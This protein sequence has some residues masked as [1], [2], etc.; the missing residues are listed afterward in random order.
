[1]RSADSGTASDRPR[2]SAEDLKPSIEQP[3]EADQPASLALSNSASLS[4][5]WRMAGHSVRG[6]AH[7]KM[8]LP[9]QD[10]IKL[11]P[12]TGAGPPPFIL[13]ISD[14][15]GSARHFRSARGSAMA[16]EAA[17]VILRDFHEQCAALSSAEAQT[18]MAAL[19]SV[20]VDR[21]RQTVAADLAENPLAED[22][23]ANVEAAEGGSSRESVESE[24]ILAYGATIVAA[25]IS[26]NFI[27]L[28][29]LG[30]GDV[31]AVDAT[32]ITSRVD[33]RDPR[34]T[35]KYSS[36]LCQADA[37]EWMRLH[38]MA[39]P[40]QWPALILICSDGYANSFASQADF[41]RIGRDYF[42]M[43]RAGGLDAVA[44]ELP[45]I[46]TYASTN[47]NGDDISLGILTRLADVPAD[48]PGETHPQGALERKAGNRGSAHHGRLLIVLVLAALILAGF[49]STRF[50]LNWKQ[51][52]SI[53]RARSIGAPPSDAHSSGSPLRHRPDQK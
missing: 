4:H 17:V 31:L 30:D 3:P 9:N 43:I 19:P 36:S 5:C 52:N 49:V 50:Y 42:E 35:G 14:G 46:L 24:P 22:E 39:N 16:V 48:S 10:A 29:Q 6:A 32:G 28:L 18:A 11:C 47:G 41:L 51:P 38:L 25:L 23:L 2:F 45:R 37:P 27:L 21:W 44:S 26:E 12:P 53:P 7:I 34:L 33:I 40:D 8:D 13:A 1:M 20:L 15:H